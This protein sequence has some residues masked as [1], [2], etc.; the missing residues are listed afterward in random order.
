MAAG[1]ARQNGLTVVSD[2]ALP[3]IGVDCFVMSVPAGRSPAAA[4]AALAR[5]P[6]VAWS[7]P[8]GVYHTKGGAPAPNDPLFRV[9]PAAIEWR[10][11]DLHQISTG[12]GVRVAVID[13]MIE[14]N[15]HNLAGQVADQPRTSSTVS[16]QSAG[17]GPMAPA[18]PGSSRL[19]PATA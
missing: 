4:A 17:A 16:P 13:S 8:M 5:D 1:L 19:G 10:L 14:A 2:W 18:S 15:H 3:L 7:E 11:A 12:R 6:G 9:Q